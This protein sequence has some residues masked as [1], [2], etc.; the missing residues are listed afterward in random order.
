VRFVRL[1]GITTV[2]WMKKQH[3][4][5]MAGKTFDWSQL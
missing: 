5:S 3:D 1:Q 2:E 4:M